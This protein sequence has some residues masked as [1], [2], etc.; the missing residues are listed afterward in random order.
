MDS[1]LTLLHTT[2]YQNRTERVKKEWLLS[3]SFAYN[4]TPKQNRERLKKRVT[5]SL[6]SLYSVLVKHCM[7]K[8]GKRAHSFEKENDANMGNFNKLNPNSN[9][10]LNE[11]NSSFFPQKTST[12]W[13]LMVNVS[14]IHCIIW[15]NLNPICHWLQSIHSVTCIY[16]RNSKTCT[17]QAN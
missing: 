5:L 1:F 11:K 7:Q 14:L 3:Y 2:L 16:S 15:E 6:H 12:F 13:L 10:N 4:A 17:N 9:N 8:S